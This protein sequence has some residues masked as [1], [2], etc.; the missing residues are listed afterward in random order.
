MLERVQWFGHGSFAINSIPR[1]FINPRRIPR[2]VEP[3]DL[4]LLSHDHHDHFSPADVEKLCHDKTIVIGNA[5][6]ARQFSRVQVLRPLHSLTLGRACVKAVPAYSPTDPRHPLEDGGLGFIISVNFFDIYYA[7]DTQIIPEMEGIKPDI[8]LLPID[9]RGTMSVSEA[10]R[11]TR[12]IRPR[13]VIPYNW[14]ST[15][16]GA[17]RLDAQRL[18]VEVGNAASVVLPDA[19]LVSS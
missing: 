15:V 13:W 16:S 1:I 9:G 19:S 11:L 17:T 5:R 12:M 10:A 6:L 3:A 7:G 14:G 4:I 8:A 18:V 2:S